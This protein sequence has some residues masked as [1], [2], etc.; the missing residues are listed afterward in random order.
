MA[1]I[2]ILDM[3]GHSSYVHLYLHEIRHYSNFHK[4]V[5]TQNKI[6]L[7]KC[8]TSTLVNTPPATNCSCHDYT[9]ALKVW[10]RWKE[11]NKK[12][13][14]TEGVGMP[15][16][17][18]SLCVFLCCLFVCVNSEVKR[19]FEFEHWNGEFHLVYTCEG[20]WDGMW[21]DECFNLCVNCNFVLSR[22]EG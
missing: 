1:N 17:S 16:P 10:W 7:V 12:K 22:F 8:F 14:K 18:P 3:G 11:K 4:I 21:W 6:N 20:N 13:A 15:L 2:K 19:V 5:L 9:T